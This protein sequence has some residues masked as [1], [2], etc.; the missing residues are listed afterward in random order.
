MVHILTAV[1][2]NSLCRPRR[3]PPPRSSSP[4]PM[5]R[6]ATVQLQSKQHSNKQQQ[7]VQ[8][9]MTRRSRDQAKHAMLVEGRNASVRGVSLQKDDLGYDGVRAIR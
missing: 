9:T 6:R 1:R 2:F 7:T 8:V 4:T 3:R 5:E